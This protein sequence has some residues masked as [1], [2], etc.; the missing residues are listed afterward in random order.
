[1][2]LYLS[3]NTRPDIAFAVSQ[4]CRFSSAPKKSHATAVKMILRYLKKTMDK[5]LL[6]KPTKDML[7]LKMY[8][9]ADFCGL[10]GQEDERDP[11]SVRSRTGYIITLGGWP[12]VWKSRLQ[13]TLSQSTTEAEYSALSTSLRV[14]MPLRWLITEIVDQAK[15]AIL[16]DTSVLTTVFEDNQSAYYLATNQR[17]TN[18]TKYYQ[19]KWHW[20][21]ELYNRGEFEIVK[22]PTS[23]Q[24]AD[25][26]TK[27]LSKVLFENNRKMVQGW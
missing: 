9:D 16:S 25:Y 21:W 6:I 23:E 22:C 1:M 4:V 13:D 19:I 18:R 3:T 17:I 14:L 15:D 26:L 8:V 5:G 7:S 11:N 2:L 24:A 20:F 12:I 10:Y 27:P